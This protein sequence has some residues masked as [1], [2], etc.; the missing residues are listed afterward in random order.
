[1]AVFPHL[2]RVGVLGPL[3]GD[4]SVWPGNVPL[5]RGQ[6]GDLDARTGN[7]LGVSGAVVLDATGWLDWTGELGRRTCPRPRRLDAPDGRLLCAGHGGDVAGAPPVAPG[8]CPGAC[9]D[10]PVF[11]L[12]AMN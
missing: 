11:L 6:S 9:G 7:L 1:S 12:C 5:Q 2:P 3:A 8:G 4:H 10:R